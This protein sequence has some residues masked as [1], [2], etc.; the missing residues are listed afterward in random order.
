MVNSAY[1]SSELFTSLLDI[2]VRLRAE[3]GCPWDRAQTHESIRSNLIEE[4]YEALEAIDT[5]DDT[6]LC[7]ELGDVLL[8]VVFH[9]RIA[10]E[11]GAFGI[12]DVLSGLCDKL[13]TRHEHVFGGVKAENAAE[14]LESW[15]NAKQK[16][17]QDESA[18][19]R[20]KAVPEAMP[21]LMRASKVQSRADKADGLVSPRNA[22]YDEE[23]AGEALWALVNDIRLSG[24]DPEQALR[25]KCRSFIADFAEKHDK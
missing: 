10:E 2:M 5:H 22:L 24:I 6:L 1:D 4:T 25:A 3:N 20:L 21:A 17:K 13:I 7:E 11:R 19:M 9:A 15:N 18:A 8:Q 16:A 12:G 14:A 23:T